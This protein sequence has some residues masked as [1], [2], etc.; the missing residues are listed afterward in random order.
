MRLGKGFKGKTTLK[1]PNK[2][3]TPKAIK[4]LEKDA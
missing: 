4:M 1:G 2:I 3:A